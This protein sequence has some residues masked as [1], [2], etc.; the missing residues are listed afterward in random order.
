MTQAEQ[1]RHKIEGMIIFNELESD[2]MYSE[3][4]IA[5]KIGIGRTPT[6]EAL[7]RL[8]HDNM[9]C[10]FP[11]KG[12]MATTITADMQLNLLEIRRFLE[13]QCVQLAT[14]RGTVEQ[15]KMMYQLA[16]KFF[17]AADHLDEYQV[18]ICL[19]ETHELLV[20]AAHNPFFA[21]VLGPL[22]GLS[23]RFWFC[24]KETKDTF[25]GAR[26]HAA[27]LENTAKGNQNAA[28]ESCENLLNYL[29]DF[30]FSRL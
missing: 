21:R 28:V 22:Q 23:R 9:I 27:I 6:R 17:L 12:V 30:T 24:D 2:R 29:T 3:S 11:R 16:Q 4:Q 25:E 19:R 15:K 10:I 14:L 18:F 5:A 7:Q 8:A 26:L 13:P 20:E 1:A